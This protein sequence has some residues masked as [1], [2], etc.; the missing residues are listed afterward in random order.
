MSSTYTRLIGLCLA[1]ACTFIGGA[2]HA[3]P[4]L[5][6]FEDQVPTVP[7]YDRGALTRL[8]LRKPSF[9][10]DIT[11]PGSSFNLSENWLNKLY[12]P[13]EDFAAEFGRVSLAPFSDK[14]GK[15]PFVVRFSKPVRAVSVQ[16]GNFSSIPDSL[17]LQAFATPD[18]SGKPLRTVR[19]FL[20]KMTYGFRSAKLT[21][22]ASG[23]RS[24]RMIGGNEKYPN[25]VYYDC[26][27]VDAEQP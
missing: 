5:F 1:A 2:A 8:T 6:D 19:G 9:E 26:L 27:T 3:D 10:I 20:P 17:L 25:N 16:M 4:I 7:P 11:R 23:I 21:L 14:T 18:A 13:N 24:I 12:E 15:S 22:E